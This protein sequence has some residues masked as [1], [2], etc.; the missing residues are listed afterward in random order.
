MFKLVSGTFAGRA[1]L[2]A[3]AIVFST[4]S[5]I[6]QAADAIAVDT[7]AD[8]TG[9]DRRPILRVSGASNSNW[10]AGMS[11]WAAAPSSFPNMRA[12]TSSRSCRS[13]SYR[14]HFSTR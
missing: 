1:S 4:H 14:R 2:A 3:M 13:L 7:D 6:V 9:D 11:S 10:P 12:A 8:D 5:E